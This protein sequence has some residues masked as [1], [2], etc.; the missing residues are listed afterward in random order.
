MRRGYRYNKPVYSKETLDE[1]GKQERKHK[2]FV[3]KHSNC[4]EKIYEVNGYFIKCIQNKYDACLGKENEYGV[5][6]WL[7][8]P[9][10]VTADKVFENCLSNDW[11][12]NAEEANKYF[13]EM[14]AMC[15]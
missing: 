5:Q 2:E 6:V 10:E 14:K 9:E 8:N 1:W 11:F 12:D 13:K 7:R 15:Y 4:T 3:K